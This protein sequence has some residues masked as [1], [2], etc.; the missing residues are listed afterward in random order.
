MGVYRDIVESK[1][2]AITEDEAHS[3]IAVCNI[4]RGRNDGTAE[5]FLEVLSRRKGKR[6][7]R[8]GVLWALKNPEQA[9]VAFDLLCRTKKEKQKKV[10]KL[11]YR[12]YL[13]S[14]GWKKRRQALIESFPECVMCGVKHGLLLHHLNYKTLGSETLKD[15]VTM[16]GDCHEFMHKKYGRGASFG[17]EEIREERAKREKEKVVIG[18]KYFVYFRSGEGIEVEGN[19]A[20]DLIAS[21]KEPSEFFVKGEYAMRVSEIV[22]IRPLRRGIG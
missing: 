22:C 9:K 7:K 18:D 4:W 12:D 3:F 14:D 15:V 13:K 10:V 1:Q 11:E 8:E 17:L 5:D 20:K 21:L 16:C 19:L 6:A 2:I